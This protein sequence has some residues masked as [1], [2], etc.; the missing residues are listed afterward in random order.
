MTVFPP[1]AMEPRRPKTM[2][3]FKDKPYSYELV[4]EY[5]HGEKKFPCA[6]AM[7]WEGKTA[8]SSVIRG[9]VKA[10]PVVERWLLTASV[11]MHL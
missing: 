4:P 11:I 7:H 10:T 1:S 8:T 6:K 9:F 2:T 5:L 3:K